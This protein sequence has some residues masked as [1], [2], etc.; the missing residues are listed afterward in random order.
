M[1][2]NGLRDCHIVKVNFCYL[3]S[4]CLVNE[5]QLRDVG[6]EFQ[7]PC[8]SR[9]VIFENCNFLR[10]RSL[11]SKLIQVCGSFNVN[12]IGK[13]SCVRSNSEDSSQHRHDRKQFQN[14]I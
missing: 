9:R 4:R 14:K 5:L 2:E 11:N 13:I 7:K 10:V 6:L 3:C 12:I 8:A 1:L